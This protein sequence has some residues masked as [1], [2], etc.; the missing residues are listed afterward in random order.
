MSEYTNERALPWWHYVLAPGL[1]VLAMGIA[2][3]IERAG[4][5]TEQC[6][7]PVDEITAAYI[8]GYN[9][10]VEDAAPDSAGGG[11]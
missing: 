9:A 10:G 5:Q 4:G 1:I 3:G 6:E 2:G 11:V 7:Y 8:R